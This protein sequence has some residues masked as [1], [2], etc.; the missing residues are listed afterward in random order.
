MKETVGD[1]RGIKIKIYLQWSECRF[2]THNV[3]IGTAKIS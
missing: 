3:V 1:T 2:D